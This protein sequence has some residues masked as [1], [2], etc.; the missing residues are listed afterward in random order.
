MDFLSCAIHFV[1]KEELNTKKET[2]QMEK[3]Q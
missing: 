1:L 3:A 2:V